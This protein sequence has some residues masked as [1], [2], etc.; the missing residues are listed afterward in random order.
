MHFSPSGGHSVIFINWLRDAQNKIVGMKYFSSNL[1]GTHG[2]G[3]GQ[4]HFSDSTRNHH[5]I[6]RKSLRIV[7][8]GAIKDYKPFN[9]ANIPA[10]N[11]YLPTQPTRIIYVPAPASAAP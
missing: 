4:G 1:S 5:G 6:I 9:R 3:Y 2:V 8:V 11:A 7:R 10:R